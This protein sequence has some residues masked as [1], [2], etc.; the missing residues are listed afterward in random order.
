MTERKGTIVPA[1]HGEYDAYVMETD[2]IR[3]VVA[4]EL[5]ANIVSMLYKPTGKEWLVAPN[6]GRTRRNVYGDRYVEPEMLGWDEC[7]PTIVACPYP[8]EG[9]FAG[10]ELPDHGEVWAL[11]WQAES[12]GDALTCKVTGVALPYELTRRIVLAGEGRLRF[13]YT[14]TNVGEA[15]FVSFWTA[16]PLFAVT[17]STR[18]VFPQGTDRVLCVDGRHGLEAGRLYDWPRSADS[19]YPDLD[20]IRPLG[21]RDSRKFYAPDPVAVGR[22]GL[23]DQASG[24]YVVLRWSPDELPYFGVWINE[25]QFNDQLI[26]APEPCNGYYDSLAL[27]YE[28]GRCPELPAGGTLT[29]TLELRLGKGTQAEM[30]GESE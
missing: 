27:A 7:Y 26:A 13:E 24:E 9:P 2:E 29:W 18:V 14:L 8:A 30:L 10:R 6:A 20:L 19:P 17:D 12:A 23:H 1:R 5:G 22:A 15:A 3:L 4:P 28:Y 21:T 16:H 11:P 25:G